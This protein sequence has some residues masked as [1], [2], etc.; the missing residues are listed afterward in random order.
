M[1]PDDSVSLKKQFKVFPFGQQCWDA[2]WDM[3]SFQESDRQQINE[4]KAESKE[5]LKKR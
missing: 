2:I 4:S 5:K 3:F 1:R